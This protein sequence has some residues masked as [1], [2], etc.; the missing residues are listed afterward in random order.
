MKI[1]NVANALILVFA[2]V[3]LLIFGKSLLFPFLFDLLI[4]FLIRVIRRLIDRLLY[5]KNYISSLIIFALLEFT[6]QIL[7]IN[8]LAFINSF[9]NY[10]GNIDS[11]VTQINQLT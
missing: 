3:I 11:I 4:Y 8:S 9:S 5:I 10:Q 6:L 7:L 2:C 1:A